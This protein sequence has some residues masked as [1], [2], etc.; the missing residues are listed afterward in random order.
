[1][2]LIIHCSV[3]SFAFFI[4]VDQCQSVKTDVWAAIF[5]IYVNV[6][7]R[8]TP[9]SSVKLGMTQAFREEVKV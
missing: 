9:N 4:V 6:E 5:N 2:L 1:M 8:W 7:V 3:Y